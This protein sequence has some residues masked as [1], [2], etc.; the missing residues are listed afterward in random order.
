M[1]LIK[2]NIVST[3][4]TSAIVAG[5]DDVLTRQADIVDIPATGRSGLAQRRA[6]LGGDNNGVVIDFCAA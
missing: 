3:E 4:A 5:G 2:I 6:Y 1:Y